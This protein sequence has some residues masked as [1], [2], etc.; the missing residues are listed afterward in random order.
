[1]AV[2]IEVV[3]SV[4]TDT[5]LTFAHV[6][7]R[8][9]EVSLA[10]GESVASRSSIRLLASREVITINSSAVITRLATGTLADFTHVAKRAHE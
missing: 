2:T 7:A 5:C 1:L 6:G 8:Q 9:N 4:T 3:D 10:I